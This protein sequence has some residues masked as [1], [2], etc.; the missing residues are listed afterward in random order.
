MIA[1]VEASHTKIPTSY[2]AA[3]RERMASRAWNALARRLD[4]T[5]LHQMFTLP[6]F[7]ML[8]SR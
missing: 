7:D 6:G 5:H 8:E 1:M 2:V 4:Y 3:E